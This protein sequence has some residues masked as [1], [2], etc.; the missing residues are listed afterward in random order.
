MKYFGTVILTLIVAIGII[1]G[2]YYYFHGYNKPNQDL[3][4]TTATSQAVTQDTAKKMLAENKEGGFKLYLQGS[5]VI[6]EHDGASNTFTGWSEYI[7]KKEPTMYY[8]DFNKDGKKELAVKVVSGI[9]TSL[10]KELYYYDL[11]ILTPKKNKDGSYDYDLIVAN[12]DT[13]KKPYVQLVKCNVTQLKSDPSRIQVAMC[14]ADDSL[15]FD[16]KTGITTSK[17]VGYSRG[18]MDGSGEYMNV[19]GW[20]RGIGEYTIDG[21]DIGVDIAIR[22]A[23]NEMVN[24]RIVGY[25][26]CGLEMQ[27]ST[28]TIKK[29]SIYYRAA[30]DFLI[31][32]PRDT[33]KKN[34]SYTITNLASPASSTD[35]DI[36]WAEGSFEIPSDGKSRDMSFIA[37]DSEIK[38]VDTVRVS[39][40][41]IVLTA[42]EGYAFVNGN[43][44]ARDYSV[45]ITLDGKEYEI[46][47][48]AAISE[49]AQGRSVLTIPLDKSY[50]RSD[51]STVTVKF[52]A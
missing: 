19:C 2:V 30:E 33:A 15:S 25:V 1:V 35:F 22:V 16:E 3:T 41:N 51:L 14:N 12:R 29:N 40:K 42:K 49:N 9:D 6:L 28:F 39:N 17:Y 50:K 4:L 44:A 34:W 13:W 37:M 43:I 47:K 8:E 23:F 48:T 31:T 21:S 20:G 5:K 32:D 11:Y 10:G 26:H 36:N 27:G 45:T 46:N 38:S 52:G 18:L 24:V 7:T